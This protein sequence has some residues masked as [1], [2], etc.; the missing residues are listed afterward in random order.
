MGLLAFYRI[1]DPKRTKLGSRT[2]NN[3]FVEY[4]ENSKAYKLLD[5]DSNIIVESKDVEFFETKFINELN[6]FKHTQA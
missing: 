5:L 6:E 1:F 3:V 2:F 4:A